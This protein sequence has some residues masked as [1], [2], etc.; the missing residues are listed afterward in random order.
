V[1]VAAALAPTGPVL[2]LKVALDLPA[3]TVNDAG[4][5]M[6][7]KFEDSFM[8]TPPVGAI[9]VRVTV[10]TVVAPPKTVD[11][12]NVT[13]ETT[14]VVMVNV[15]VAV[16]PLRLAVITAPV[17]AVTAAVLTVKVPEV[18][19]EVIVTEAADTVADFELLASLTEK[20]ALGAG[21][22]RVIVAVEVPPPASVDGLRVI[23]PRPIGLTVS[24]AD[25]VTPDNVPVT[26][27]VCTVVTTV[28]VA[29][30]FPELWPALI[31]ADAGTTN[32]EL[33]L[34]NATV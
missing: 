22:V 8:G 33:L 2:T 23:E 17:C 25:C 24:V 29:V 26:L 6:P 1:I 14:G 3:E 10:P 11:G 20:P 27:T 18:F 21:P 16:I 30:K 5:V 4:M 34:F 7:A 15:A 12:L 32:A 19:P 31:E 9:P 13:V 28:V